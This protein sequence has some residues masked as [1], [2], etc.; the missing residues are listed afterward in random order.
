[1]VT[2]TVSMLSLP[3]PNGLW[4]QKP[5]VRTLINDFRAIP[6]KRSLIKGSLGKFFC[7]RLRP[8]L[9]FCFWLYVAKLFVGFVVDL[10][11]YFPLFGIVFQVLFLIK[12]SYL[13]TIYD[14]AYKSK[15]TV[16]KKNFHSLA[17]I[18]GI[19]MFI[20]IAVFFSWL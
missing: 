18:Q 15:L 8:F 1:M 6:D 5:V 3:T 11:N 16:H 17:F 14:C 4:R 10:K 2:P 7:V 20:K 12:N 19:L 13:G 9:K